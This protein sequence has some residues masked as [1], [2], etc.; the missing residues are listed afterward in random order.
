MDTYA[1]REELLRRGWTQG[2][3]ARR[4]GFTQAKVSRY[5]TGKRSPNLKSFK[6]MC[7]VLGVKAERI[8]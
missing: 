6:R 5:L 2:E 7:E 8:W 1:I 3:F 4:C